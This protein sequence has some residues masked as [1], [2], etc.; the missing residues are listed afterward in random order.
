MKTYLKFAGAVAFVFALV[1]F[2][3]LMATP[4][5]YSNGILGDY[6]YPGTLVIFGGE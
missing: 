4:G 3:L 5:A 6:N 1:A 2:I